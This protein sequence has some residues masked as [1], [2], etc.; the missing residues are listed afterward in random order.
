M[1]EEQ[2]TKIRWLNRAFHAEKLAK[3]LEAKLQRDKSLAQRL[4]RCTGSLAKDPH[5]NS[6]ETAL[7]RL[8]ETEEKLHGKLAELAVLREEISA[9]ID[10]VEDMELQCILIRHYLDYETFEVIAERM[11][12]DE[13]TVR[14]KHK[15]ALEKVVL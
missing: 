3:A 1:T 8:A 12:Y 15:K 10:S 2:L 5:G 4:S 14:R 9:A 11:H 7:I 13:R 6:T